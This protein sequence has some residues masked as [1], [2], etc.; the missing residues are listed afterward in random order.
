MYIST[1]TGV[2]NSLIEE[3]K[4]E[5]DRNSVSVWFVKSVI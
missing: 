2:L 1:I 3:F 5:L 4:T